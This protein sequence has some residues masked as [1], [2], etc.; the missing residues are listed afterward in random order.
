MTGKAGQ[1]GHMDGGSGSA[2][3]GRS[4]DSISVSTPQL[5]QI[6]P[7]PIPTTLE[8]LFKRVKE[9]DGPSTEPPQIALATTGSTTNISQEEG[10]GI[11]IIEENSP[12]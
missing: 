4:R 8:P 6:P 7:F 12:S 9:A 5:V 2:T 3:G 11:P 10:W 1:V